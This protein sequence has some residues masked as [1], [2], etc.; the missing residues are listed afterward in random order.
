MC[1]GPCGSIV[2]IGIRRQGT[3][4]FVEEIREEDFFSL[5]RPVFDSGRSWTPPTW[6]KVA[7]RAEKFTRCYRL[8]ERTL[9]DL[10]TPSDPQGE[11]MYYSTSTYYQPS[12]F[13]AGFFLPYNIPYLFSFPFFFFSLGNTCFL[14]ERKITVRWTGWMTG[15]PRKTFGFLLFFILIIFFSWISRA[16]SKKLEADERVKVGCEVVYLLFHLCNSWIVD[17]YARLWHVTWAFEK[18]SLLAVRRTLT[19]IHLSDL[20]IPFRHLE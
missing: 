16:P 10:Q 4:M 3:A 15:F 18:V 6:F 2:E 5:W 1:K 7:S 11:S 17:V 8:F 12:A 19:R 20:D 9:V 14:H 13:M